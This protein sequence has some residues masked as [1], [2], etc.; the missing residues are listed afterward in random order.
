MRTYGTPKLLVIA[1]RDHRPFALGPESLS[2]SLECGDEFLCVL[3][4]D[5]IL[6][7]LSHCYHEDV[8]IISVQSEIRVVDDVLWHLG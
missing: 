2:D 5:S 8:A 3:A 7:R 1:F 4:V 6:R